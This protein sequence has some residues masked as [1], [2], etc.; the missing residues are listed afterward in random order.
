[1]PPPHQKPYTLVIDLECL[2]QP[3][4]DVRAALRDLG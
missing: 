4:W 2:V 1:L 3:V